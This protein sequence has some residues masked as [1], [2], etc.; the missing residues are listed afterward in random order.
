M[1]FH[2]KFHAALRDLHI[3]NAAL[4]LESGIDPTSISRY[5]TGAR[6]IPSENGHL[7]RLCDA[8]SKL[9]PSNFN[10]LTLPKGARERAKEDAL[11]ADRVADILFSWFSE[12]EEH[13]DDGKKEILARKDFG[14][15][16]IALMDAAGV[17]NIQVARALAVDGSTISHY[18]TGLRFPSSRSGFV[19][20][21]SAYICQIAKSHRQKMLIANIAGLESEADMTQE[22]LQKALMRWFFENWTPKENIFGVNSFLERVDSFRYAGSGVLPAGVIPLDKIAP[23]AGDLSGHESYWGVRGVQSAS[24]RFLYHA[25]MQDAPRTLFLHSDQAM[26]WMIVDPKFTAVW[27]S[28]MV[29]TLMKGNRIKIIHAVDRPEMS[30]SIERWVPLYMTGGIEPYYL[31]TNERNLFRNTL[32]IADSLACITSSCVAGTEDRAEYVYDTDQRQIDSA[33]EQFD[34]LLASSSEL[35]RIYRGQKDIPAFEMRKNV[36]WSQGGDAALLTPSLSLA[37]MPGELLS[38]MLTRAGVEAAKRQEIMRLH[39][40]HEGWLTRQIAHGNLDDF[41]VAAGAEKSLPAEKAFCIDIPAYIVPEPI[42]Y[43]PEEYAAHLEHAREMDRQNPNYRFWEL[44]ESPLRYIRIIQRKKGRK[45][46]TIFERADEQLIAFAFNN[47][48]MSEGFNNFLASM[49]KKARRKFAR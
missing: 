29:H 1:Q 14:E 27:A 18:R 15:K 8:I 33:K 28:L 4:A 11:N 41:S 46:E 20:K 10:A 6:P 13:P 44:P 45:F 24:I 42:A 22:K 37:S 36:F 23:L 34:A 19:E 30:E 35:M 17:S 39:A 3:T 2:E 26:D 47:S 49:K 7:R 25:A 40:T 16:L 21:I 12:E 5:R 32:F 9:L 48:Q 43:T 38:S 31:K